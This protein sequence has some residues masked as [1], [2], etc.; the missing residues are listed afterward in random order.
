MD[1]LVPMVDSRVAFAARCCLCRW[2]ARFRPGIWKL[3][4]ALAEILLLQPRGCPVPLTW[5]TR[6]M[7]V[8]KLYVGNLSFKATEEQ[9]Q[10]LFSED[11]RAAGFADACCETVLPDSREASALP[12]C[13][14]M[15]KP[16]KSSQR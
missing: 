13:A 12:K 2:S 1:W 8:K 3:P 11:R 15:P 10:S 4:E 16:K 6:S 7:I 5:G 9:V 14:T